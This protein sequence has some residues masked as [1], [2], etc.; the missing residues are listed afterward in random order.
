MSILSL[1]SRSPGSTHLVRKPSA[2]HWRIRIS[3]RCRVSI[4]CEGSARKREGAKVCGEGV[5]HFLQAQPSDL[6]NRHHAGKN[7]HE[8]IPNQLGEMVRIK[9]D[10]LTIDMTTTNDQN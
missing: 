10:E 4:L 3:F 8:K 5:S 1:A 7:N 6:T 2:F 9:Q